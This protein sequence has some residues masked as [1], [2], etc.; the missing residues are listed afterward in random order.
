MTQQQEVP[1]PIQL[2]QMITAKLVS[3][4]IYVAAKL[5]IA[6]LV[7]DHPRTAEE[8]A[9]A[10]GTHAPSLY[11]VLRALS[12]VGIFTQRGDGKFETTPMAKLLESGPQGLR[13]MAVMFGEPWH[14]RPWTELLHCVKTGE[15]GFERAMGSP[16]FDYLGQNAEAAAVFN[17]AM[18]GFTNN[19]AQAVL[20]SYSFAGIK[21]LVDIAGG[22]GFLL[23]TILKATPGLHGVLFDLPQVVEGSAP[24]IAEVRDR[25]EVVGGSFFEAIP[26]SADAYCLKHIIHDW[27]DER[28]MQIMKNIHRAA[29]PEARLLII[30]MVIPDGNAPFFG[31]LLDLEMLVMTQGG[32]ERTEAEYRKLLGDAGWRLN[33]IVETQSATSV[34]EAIRA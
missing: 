30:E 11:R 2:S 7:K 20:S 33:R 28:S 24:I 1:L 27:D 32:K 31:K 17:D 3:K 16:A 9:R 29:P 34:I 15:P 26:V 10:T 13:G 22:H 21:K 23:K 6:D 19:A 18:T 4:P 14:D 25:C 12:S 8:L 5:G